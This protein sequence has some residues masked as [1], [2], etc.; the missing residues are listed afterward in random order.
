MV[1]KRMIVI[2][3]LDKHVYKSNTTRLRHYD[4]LGTA[5]FVTFSCYRRHPYF[6]D[7]IC[8]R[9]LMDQIRTLREDH[10]VQLLGYVVMAD[11]VHLV[12]FP[13]NGLK[14]GRLIGQ[15]KGR[16][17]RVI[18]SLSSNLVRRAD[19]RPA[20]WQRRCYDHNCRKAETVREKIV[21]CHNNPVRRGLVSSPDEWRWSSYRWY[22][23]KQEVPLDIDGIAL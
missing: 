22:Q 6:A 1:G 20:V 13:P 8:I 2:D 19:G 9:A 15:M 14:L 3:K 5:R 16:S 7:E 12:L 18:T 23:G 21:Y 17:A 4:N 11:H 10:A